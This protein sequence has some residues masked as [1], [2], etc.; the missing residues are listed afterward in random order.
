MKLLPALA[1]VILLTA[2]TADQRATTME[3]DLTSLRGQWVVVNYWASWCKPC[4]EEIPQLKRLHGAYSNLTVVGVNYDGA[5]G[6][7][8]HA[9]AQRLGVGFATLEAD[10]S[11]QLGIPRP[12]V[13]PT[14]LILDPQGQL[15]RTLLGPQTVESLSE[16]AGLAGWRPQE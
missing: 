16:A 14:T 13:L 8:L 2:C 7:E 3:S 6:E 15:Q 10:P 9:Q 12:A 4:I 11:A 1:C 5:S